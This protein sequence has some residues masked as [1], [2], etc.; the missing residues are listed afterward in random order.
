MAKSNTRIE[1]TIEAW[2]SRELGQDENFVKVVEIDEKELNEA[3]ELQQIS[4][5]LQKSLIAD[6]KVIAKLHGIGYQTLMR[7]ILHRFAD[8]ETKRLAREM[9]FT[10][11]NESE[12]EETSEQ[13]IE[14][15]SQ[16]G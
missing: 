8:C 7:Q 12:G 16:C 2:E 11:N 13:S 14:P 10:N 4:I 5:R 15:K 3:A 1:G 9:V 6:F